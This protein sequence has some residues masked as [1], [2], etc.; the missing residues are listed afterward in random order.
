VGQRLCEQS[1]SHKVTAQFALWDFLRELGEQEVGGT[2][3]LKSRNLREDASRI[4][5][6]KERVRNLAKMYAWWM[7][8][9]AVSIVLLKASIAYSSL[10]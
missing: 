4:T 7:A 1:H 6:P 8:K 2:E 3:L 10:C 9:G 5:V